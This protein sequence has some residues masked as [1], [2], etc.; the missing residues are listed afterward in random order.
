[1][2]ITLLFLKYIYMP[3]QNVLSFDMS[4]IYNTHFFNSLTSR[5]LLDVKSGLYER[6]VRSTTSNG[7][8]RRFLDGIL[9]TSRSRTR[10][11]LFSGNKITSNGYVFLKTVVFEKN[12]HV[13][14][15]LLLL[16]FYPCVIL[17]QLVYR[18]D[19]TVGSNC[20]LNIQ[21]KLYNSIFSK[22]LFCSLKIQ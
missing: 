22:I 7:L 1:M 11:A 12:S 2:L 4:F 18:K 9:S 20:K 8:I 3:T 15:D 19:I 10:C 13:C 16:S 6:L 14:Y 21:S 5:T 17:T